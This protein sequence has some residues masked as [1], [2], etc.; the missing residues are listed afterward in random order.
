MPLKK[1]VTKVAIA[2]SYYPAFAGVLHRQITLGNV[3]GEE[4]QLR[5]KITL[6]NIVGEEHQL[7][8]NAVGEEHQLRR[9]L[10]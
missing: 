6:G 7:R 10:N 9:K 8:R 2:K 1:A 3:V 4:H 5:R